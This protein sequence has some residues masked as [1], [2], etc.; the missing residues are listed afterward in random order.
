MCKVF[1]DVSEQYLRQ[2]LH[3]QFQYILNVYWYQSAQPDLYNIWKW[4]S[5]RKGMKTILYLSIFK[6]IKALS[7]WLIFKD[8]C[9]VVNCHD[10]KFFQLRYRPIHAF[11]LALDMFL[12]FLHR[13]R[14]G[15]HWCL[16]NRWSIICMLGKVVPLSNKRRTRRFLELPGWWCH[17]ANYRKQIFAQFTKNIHVCVS[18]WG[19]ET[20]IAFE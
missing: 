3:F 4:S 10:A 9:L 12:L 11:T 17:S 20:Y 16:F 8:W 1:K 19:Y 6:Q 18:K 5:E 2:V 13:V 15:H 14:S 7:F